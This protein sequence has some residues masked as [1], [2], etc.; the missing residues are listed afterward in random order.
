[1]TTKSYRGDAPAVAK[2]VTIPRPVAY[3]SG[4]VT[5]VIDNKK[6]S[7][8][9]WDSVVMADLWNN[10][11]Y[12]ETTNVFASAGDTEDGNY[13]T[14]SA[15]LVLTSTIPGED[16]FVDVYLGDED[17]INITNEVQ[18]LTF[19]PEPTGGTF[20]LTFSGQ[21]TSAITYVTNNLGQTAANILAA[22]EALSNIAPGDVSVSASSPTVF[23][24]AFAGTY[25]NTNVSEIIATNVDLVSSLEC[26]PSTTQIRVGVLPT[27]EVQVL[28]LPNAPTGGTFTLTYSG[29]TTAAIAYNASA[30]TVQSALEALSNIAVGDV[31]CTGGSLPGT[32]V[33]ITFGSTLGDQDVALITGNGGSLT[34]G[35]SNVTSFTTVQGGTVT[36][37]Q[38]DIS[39][40][41]TRNPADFNSTTMVSF[42]F[43]DSAGTLVQTT[44]VL[45]SSLT[46][47]DIKALFVG[48]TIKITSSSYLGLY[49]DYVITTD[50]IDVTGSISAAMTLV[51]SF[52]QRLASPQQMTVNG[53]R[54]GT[55][56]DAVPMSMRLYNSN[57]EMGSFLFDTPVD[58]V[59]V[60]YEKQSFRVTDV[61]QTGQ[62]TLN[63][64]D[65]AGVSHTT[66]P[67]D[68]S[69][70]DPLVMYQRI[71]NALGGEYVDIYGPVN[72]SGNTWEWRVDYFGYEV[73]RANITIM[74][75]NEG[76]VSVL[77]SVKGD[78]GIGEI[79]RVDLN[80]VRLADLTG[81]T[82]TLTYNGQTTSALAYN[83]T[84]VDIYNALVALSN[85]AAA[86]LQS[87][88]GTLTEGI[89]VIFDEL[90]G[91]VNSLIMDAD[92]LT[93]D[94]SVLAATLQTGGLEIYFE[95]TIRN[96][97]PE[98]FDDPLNYDPVGVP[99]DGD[100]VNFEYGRSSCKWGIKQRDTFTVLSTTTELMQLSTKRPLFQNG[101]KVYLTTTN[102][103]PAGL[104]ANTAYYIINMDTRG[105]FQLS[106]TEGGSPINITSSGTGTHTLGLRLG[107]F[108]KPARYEFE[109]GLPRD[110]SNGFIEYRPRY[111]EV[112]AS[113]F[114][115]GEG[116]GNDS[117]LVRIDTG[118]V[119]IS[120]GIQVYGTGS[121]RE[122]VLPALGLLINN[123][124]VDVKCYGG[125][126][127]FAPHLDESTII[128]DIDF[129]DTQVSSIGQT[130]CRNITGDEGSSLRGKFVASGTIKLGV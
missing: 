12:P 112:Y 95:E 99:S 38:R 130:T 115:L 85:I 65:A 124:T 50:D 30:A 28:S 123:N 3:T 75:G 76:V 88:S 35:S 113:Q 86:D 116:V 13:G 63:V 89:T 100:D 59:P 29:Q 26:S 118:A 4:R 105:R 2:V 51:I 128:Q 101:Q 108:K 62:Y 54:Y 73:N 48:K 41:Y 39:F 61:T 27:D 36:V 72:I 66:A 97:G 81:G 53:D 44:P 79:Q 70:L 92:D 64:F 68:Y 7:V 31:A 16:F 49:R 32:P 78:P 77:E 23:R 83:A 60:V 8:D 19:D 17:S 91:N 119:A 25:V 52:K 120:N 9:S 121:S 47:A 90:L 74:S 22:L 84:N 15:S 33:T 5:I 114:I 110:N 104:T 10:S 14:A 98:C 107:V 71:N 129:Y 58:T 117:N 96:Q 126:V 42:F 102:T 56:I 82:F 6:I 45:Y 24:I 37:P 80:P 69:E 67:I 11:G 109:I 46:A 18:T 21:T 94:S 1:M 87:V 20:T 111:L 125:D 40:R 55:G 127:G 57:L 34:G 106:T 93:T 122:S 43:R 103:A